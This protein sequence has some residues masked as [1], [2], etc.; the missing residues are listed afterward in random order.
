[1]NRSHLC[2]ETKVRVFL[3]PSKVYADSAEGWA[4]TLLIKIQH[5]L[6]RVT[7]AIELL[8]SISLVILQCKIALSSAWNQK[9]SDV[10]K[11]STELQDI[12]AVFLDVE[13]AS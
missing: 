13:E 10:F 8:P 6:A 2:Q 12:F 5:S 7:G 4:S 11:I 1:V 3:I 9:I